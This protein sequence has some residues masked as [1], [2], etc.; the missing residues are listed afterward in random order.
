MSTDPERYMGAGSA[1]AV[2]DKL[3][4]GRGRWQKQYSSTQA[5]KVVLGKMLGHVAVVPMPVSQCTVIGYDG[6]QEMLDALMCRTDG[7]TLFLE[8]ELPFKAGGAARGGFGGGGVFSVGDMTVISG[9][10]FTSV[11]SGS[12]TIIANGMMIV[13]G[14]EV[15]LDRY[16]RVV[17]MVPSTTDV[18]VSGVIGVTG[19]TDDLDGAVDFSPVI[20]SRLVASGSVGSLSADI[21]GS[22]QAEI[23]GSVTGDAEIEISGSGAVSAGTVDGAADARI[24]GSGHVDIEAGRTRRMNASVSGSG[25]VS[26]AG[27]VTGNARLRVSGSG[28]IVVAHALGDVDPRVTGSGFVKVNGATHRPRRGGGSVTVNHYSRGW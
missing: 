28:S 16:I 20:Q 4:T 24:S 3:P 26:H 17:V 11:S 2:R 1:M 12:G 27:T 15:D 10:G 22:G 23:R 8:G 6:D 18:K 14:R 7:R 13:D 5:S 21:S 9:G 25:S 19:I